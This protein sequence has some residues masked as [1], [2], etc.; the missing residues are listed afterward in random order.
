MR[1][2][3]VTNSRAVAHKSWMVDAPLA[4][5]EFSESNKHNFYTKSKTKNNTPN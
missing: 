4:L 2:T 3:P 5:P 1:V